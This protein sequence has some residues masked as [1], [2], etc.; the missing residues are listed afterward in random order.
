MPL[1]HAATR[2]VRKAFRDAYRAFVAAY[3]EAAERL[4]A[5]KLPVAFP[6]GSFPPALPFVGG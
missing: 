6:V 5:G 2:R 3:R 1:I 4:K